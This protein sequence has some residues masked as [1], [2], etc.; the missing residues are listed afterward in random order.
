MFDTESEVMH[1]LAQLHELERESSITSDGLYE[2]T[3]V[4]SECSEEATHGDDEGETTE[5]GNDSGTVRVVSYAVT[6]NN[7]GIQS[8]PKKRKKR[9]S[10][11]NMKKRK[12]SFARSG[13]YLSPDPAK[14]VPT[15]QDTPT[16]KVI[17]VQVIT[18][19]TETLHTT[20]IVDLMKSP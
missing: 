17:K 15:P 13:Y 12:I 6:T 10:K 9:K 8:A 19:R 18:T 7:A 4:G 20:T 11:P 2:G 3:S 16:K 1:G 5:S 14:A